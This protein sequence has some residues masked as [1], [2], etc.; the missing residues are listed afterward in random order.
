MT[1]TVVDAAAAATATTTTTA[2]ASGS[3]SGGEMKNDQQSIF[4]QE[5]RLF[6]NNMCPICREILTEPVISSCKKTPLLLQVRHADSW[7]GHRSAR[8]LRAVSIAFSRPLANGW[9]YQRPSKKVKRETD[10][11]AL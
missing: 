1:S 3:G 6:Y 8:S 11:R 4:E 10:C 7:I 2:A 5:E 9:N